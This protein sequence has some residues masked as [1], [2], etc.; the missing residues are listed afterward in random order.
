MF[1]SRRYSIFSLTSTHEYKTFGDYKNTPVIK[2][3]SRSPPASMHVLNE[4]ER[5]Y[6]TQLF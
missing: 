2:L 1:N 6:F 5:G 4:E 3:C